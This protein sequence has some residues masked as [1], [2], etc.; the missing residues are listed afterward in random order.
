MDIK[1]ECNSKIDWMGPAMDG[2]FFIMHTPSE[3]LVEARKHHFSMMRR[4]LL[5]IDDISRGQGSFAEITRTRI[6]RVFE[7]Y[8]VHFV[9][10]DDFPRINIDEPKE[11]EQ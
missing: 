5:E 8:N 7:K 4:F 10:V 3:T 11:P 6:K 2:D 1:K 9:N